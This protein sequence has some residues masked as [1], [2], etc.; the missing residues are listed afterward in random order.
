MAE[1]RFLHVR[2]HRGLFRAL[3][4]RG[5]ATA[6]PAALVVLVACPGCDACW[7]APLQAVLSP[8]EREQVEY[9][10]ARRLSDDCPDHAH[11]FNLSVPVPQP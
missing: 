1:L 5:F 3:A 2:V 4:E 6:S 11:R 10:A 7:F 9:D 8:D